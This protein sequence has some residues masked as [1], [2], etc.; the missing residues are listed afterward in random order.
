MNSIVHAPVQQI[1]RH[2][3][4]KEYKCVMPQ[5]QVKNGKEKGRDDDAGNGRHKQS[6]FI[7]RILMVIAMHGIG[8]FP[9]SRTFTYPVKNKPV[10]EVFKESP[11]ENRQPV[12]KGDPDIG[13]TKRCFAVIQHI[14]D[15]GQIHT[16]NNNGMGF[17]QQFQI[18]VTEDLRLSFIVYFF[19]FHILSFSASY[20][21]AFLV[22]FSQLFSHELSH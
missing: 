9:G 1:A 12:Y 20:K 3:A 4:G 13:I 6:L 16:K 14:A 11:A 7:A 18:A 10:G 22:W 8:Q 19:E 2:K 21:N 5:E 17:R 15:H